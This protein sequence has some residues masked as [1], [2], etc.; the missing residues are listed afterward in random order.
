MNRP[1]VLPRS[2]FMVLLAALLIGFSSGP[3]MAQASFWDAYGRGKA[4]LGAGHYDEAVREFQEAIRIHPSSGKRVRLYGTN[5]A[6]DYY[7]YT[8][9]GEAL[10]KAGKP[11]E[12]GEVLSAALSVGIEPR[13]PIEE[14]LTQAN[15]ARGQPKAGPSAR[16][17]DAAVTT[18]QPLPQPEVVR[19]PEGRNQKVTVHFLSVPK[20]A[21]V[22]LD[23]APR[24]VTP[25]DLQLP[26]EGNHEAILRRQ[27]F[28]D[29]KRS[30]TLR[31]GDELTVDV[32]L[33]PAGNRENL[34]AP[35]APA[36]P[37]GGEIELR[38]SPTGTEVE[39]DG[40]PR[41]GL[42][43]SGVL[44]LA[45]SPGDHALRLSHPGFQE[46]NTTIRIMA[47]I[48]SLFTWQLIPL[49][50]NPVG[51]AASPP[52]K[53]GSPG[54]WVLAGVLALA[55]ILAWLAWRATR[56]GHLRQ[57]SGASASSVKTI[58]PYVLEERLGGGGM[59]EV[60]KGRRRGDGLTAAVKMPLS[61]YNQ[62]DQFRR[63]FLQECEIGK[64]LDHP[65]VIKILDFGDDGGQLFL[66]M[67][68]VEGR[69]LR[70][71]L[72]G[73]G[74]PFTPGAAIAM[75]REVARILDYTHG[76]GVIHRDLKPENIMLDGP[77][78]K[79]RVADFGVARVL[80]ATSFTLTGQVLGTPRYMPPEP[81]LRLP[82]TP[83]SDLYSVG[84]IFY[85]MLTLRPPFDGETFLDMVQ[86]H[87]SSGRPNPSSRNS[88]VSPELDAIVTRLMAV[89]PAE[90]FSSA[91]DL[92]V[93]LDAIHCEA[94]PRGGSLFA[95]G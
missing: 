32:A 9:L 60:W 4:A 30:F 89:Q 43:S 79:V 74:E 93:A 33:A 52:A 68:Y 58:G 3:V 50:P 49:P 31:P 69:T 92:L 5:F 7:P 55:V 13:G 38:V 95:I 20:G 2:L 82:Y 19:R 23:G 94:R 80:D 65:G 29:E 34:S 18:S 61:S 16:E 40:V 26:P 81:M 62:D 53:G 27:G 8:Q 41:G 44:V 42:G 66:A 76:Q 87:H 64:R 47:G 22:I 46:V 83:M 35:K 45:L 1:R 57:G 77:S 85:E 37:D 56:S 48:R 71:K 17:S 25:L 10:L 84:V 88:L 86:L 91:K 51:Q 24:G 67:E 59:S 63:R 73:M 39:L 36:S 78:E 90:R 12:A 75:V 11:G 70:A 54:Q 28:Q 15:P 6:S 14:L 72:D 21:G